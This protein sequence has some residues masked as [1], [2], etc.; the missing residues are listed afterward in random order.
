MSKK[1][2]LIPSDVPQSRHAE[3]IANYDAI[4]HGT[5]NLF[6]F[7]CDQKME[8]LN[9]DFYGPDIAPEVNDPERLFKI[10]SQGKIGVMATNLGLISRYAQSYNNINYVV[11]LNSK[12]NIIPKNDRDPIST[13]LWSVDDVIKFKQNSGLPIRGIGYTLYIGSEYEH[14]MLNQAANMVLKAHEN[15]LVA[16]LWMYPRSANYI[17]NEQD[18]NLI[19]GAAGVANCLG[20]DFAKVKSPK[21]I[22]DLKIVTGAAGNTRIICAGGQFKDRDKFLE[23]LKAEIEVGNTVG[24]AVGRNIFERKFDDAIK[25]TEDIFNIVYK[26]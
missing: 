5:G 14:I 10:A 21:N 4:T 22:E 24:C 3:F 12:T 8:H 20:A 1:N 6:M 25:L 9:G 2:I 18:S 26:K 23:D 19:A 13:D 11:K 7:S 16:I 17:E 15:G